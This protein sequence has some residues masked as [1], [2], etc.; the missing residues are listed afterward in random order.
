MTTINTTSEEMRAVEAAPITE[1]MVQGALG[2]LYEDTNLS[3]T[4][5]TTELLEDDKVI[6]KS[7]TEYHTL[8]QRPVVEWYLRQ[9]RKFRV[10]YR[11]VQ[12]CPRL[13]GL[14]KLGQHIHNKLGLLSI[15]SRVLWDLYKARQGSLFV[16]ES[17]RQP[18]LKMV[19]DKIQRAEY[20]QLKKIG[21]YLYS[22]NQQAPKTY[23]RGAWSYIWKL[24]RGKKKSC[25]SKIMFDLM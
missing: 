1:A 19:A 15:Q 14:G 3:R 25:E 20:N 17:K 13:T 5:A 23:S 2:K 16:K 24:Y 9:P 4:P 12:S 7:M 11:A 22:L 21:Q 6:R 18:S 8:G 10:I